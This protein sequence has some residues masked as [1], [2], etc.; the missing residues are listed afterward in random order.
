MQP[1]EL[2]KQALR[3]RVCWR[4]RRGWVVLLCFLVFFG[5]ILRGETA[6]RL[7]KVVQQYALT[8]AN[9]FPQRD[10]Q[11]WRLLGSNDGGRTW[12]TLDTRKSE[13]FPER[14]QRR[15]FAV[16]KPAAFEI[17]RLQIDVVHDP[18]VANSVQLA[19]I[20]PMGATEDDLEPIPIFTDTITAQGD[21]PPSELAVKLFD[22]RMETKWLDK[23]SNR[24][25]CASWI[26]W[27]YAAPTETAVTNISQLIALRARA[28]D[29]YRVKIEAVAVGRTGA[30][31]KWSVADASGCMEISAMTGEE[32]LQ[33][34][35][36]VTFVGS[37]AWSSRKVWLTNGSVQMRGAKAA[38]MPEQ[39]VIEQLLT[40]REDLKWVEVEGEVRYRRFGDGEISFDVGDAGSA[41]RVYWRGATDLLTLPPTGTR[42]TVR[43][44]CRGAFNDQGMW[45]AAGLWAA[46]RDAV[47]L[48]GTQSRD[49]KVQSGATTA[50]SA[51]PVLGTLTKIEQIRRLTQEQLQQRPHVIFRG[52]VTE[53]FGAFM[54]DDTAGVEVAFQGNESRK[55]TEPGYYIEVEGWGGLGDAGNPV[56]SADRVTVLGKGKWPEPERMSLS[57]LMSGRTDAQWI[58]VEG[59]VRST[60]GAHLLLICYGREVT[61]SMSA[62]AA[63]LVK[64]LVDAAVRVRGVGVT[65][66]DDRGRIQGI[67]LLIP[68]LEHV[69]V[70]EPPV[71]PATLP[72]RP[73][74]SLLSL[75]GPRES[76]HRV[77]VQGVVTLQENQKLFLQDTNGGAMAILKEDVVLDARFGRSRWLFW[78]TQQT[79]APVRADLRF[80]P[81]DRVEVIGFPETRNYSPVLT[82]VTV[83]K[84][85]SG[86][87]V[88][89]YEATVNGVNDGRA[90]SQLIVVEGVLLGQNSIG[91]QVVMAL[92]WNDRTLQVLVPVKEAAALAIAPGSRLRVTGVCQ[93]DPAPYAE[94]GQRVAAVRILTRSAADLVVLAKP[95]WW[96]VQ[97][98]LMMMGGMACVILAALVWI[99]QLQ[100][101][102]EERTVQ[103]TTEI[104]LREQT[105]RR[106]ALEQ[107]RSRIAKDLHDDLGANLAQIVFLSQRVEGQ[108]DAQEMNR[109]FGLI[110]AT[111]RRTIQSLDEIVWAINPRH[112]SLES[113]ANYLSQFAQEHLTLARV[114]CVLDVPTVLPAV[115]LSAEIRH[116]LLLAT[117]EALQN[118]VTHAEAT[119]VRLILQLDEAGL[120]IAI[121]DNG[122]GFDPGSVS[123]DGNGLPNMRRRLESIGGRFEL[124]NQPGKGT[125]VR[126]F[127]PS[128]MLHGRVIGVNG[129]S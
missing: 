46:G 35:Q 103:L 81:G 100:R 70:I 72:V 22:G 61:A 17:Y 15:V 54:Q 99:N 3:A 118:A 41:M 40:A 16:S 111:A 53:L 101:Q 105:E 9:D 107:E 2:N 76:Y 44:L 128:E 48:T 8:S 113:L 58:E 27:Q 62:G 82:E 32:N 19:E 126:L 98:A 25:T 56:V 31:N 97:R 117:R 106:S 14:H 127:V 23:P 84:I 37:S 93:V 88:Q 102:V 83:K 55:V 115:P 20:E 91:T 75:S 95:S 29:G 109:Y 5:V 63:G 60:D 125:T 79:N 50:K 68:S 26:Q 89:L 120:S 73:I 129:V 11:D 39:I 10:P 108:S 78:R 87:P 90:D 49:G 18:K 64:N 94:L 33:P 38:T 59:V 4:G 122:K 112:D 123:R 65:A 86:N 7:K 36:P 110:P 34:G 47:T 6:D 30:T 51:A 13:V 43:G 24:E 71:N 96:T 66:L 104:Q 121:A 92:E 57:Q 28:G 80:A 69:D 67:H 42:V 45:V 52:V 114:R 124:D 1:V 74:G 116:N 12:T 21:N 77:K 119:E 85:G